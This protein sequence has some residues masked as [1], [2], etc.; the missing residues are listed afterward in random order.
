M[1][2]NHF[3]SYN[4][5]LSSLIFHFSPQSL[6]NCPKDQFLGVLQTC[7]FQQVSAMCVDRMFTDN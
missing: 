2:G 6:F 4:F 3:T 5:H 7:F 1:D